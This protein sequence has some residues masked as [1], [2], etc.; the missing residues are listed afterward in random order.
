[1]DLDEEK[2]LIMRV[3][4]QF[5]KIMA[6]YLRHKPRNFAPVKPRPNF[7]KHFFPTIL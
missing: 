3:L 6:Y 4:I 1:M 2:W 5:H 7:L